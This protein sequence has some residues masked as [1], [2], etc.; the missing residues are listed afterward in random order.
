[1]LLIGF[2]VVI[3]HDAQSLLL[4]NNNLEV[5]FP[6][7]T[8]Q[9]LLSLLFLPLK[10]LILKCNSLPGFLLTIS[11]TP[12]SSLLWVSFICSFRHLIPVYLPFLLTLTFSPSISSPQMSTSAACCWVFVPC[13]TYP[14]H[15]RGS[16]RHAEALL[17]PVQ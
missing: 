13:P 12:Y 14:P 6:P 8:T 16:D 9:C 4:Q 3:Q 2:P 5:N 10:C 15:C 7:L 17:L 11:N 1:M